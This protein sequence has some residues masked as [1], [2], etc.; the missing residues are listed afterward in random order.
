MYL[1]RTLLSYIHHTTYLSGLQ[2]NANILQLIIIIILNSGLI[3]CHSIYLRHYLN[4]TDEGAKLG[5]LALW[6]SPNPCQYFVTR[7][8][9]CIWQQ[10]FQSGKS[11]YKEGSNRAWYYSNNNLKQYF[12]KVED[13]RVSTWI[14][15]AQAYKFSCSKMLIFSLFFD[16][17]AVVVESK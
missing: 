7:L 5:H 16:S 8:K 13:C 2:T 14:Y 9:L 1:I 3:I 4:L 17:Q 11:D 10:H 12:Y 6:F 15:A